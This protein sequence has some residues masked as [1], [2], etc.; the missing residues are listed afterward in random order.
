MVPIQRPPS[1]SRRS[2]FALNGFLAWNRVRLGLAAGE[3]P[4]SA[5]HG[6]EQFSLVTPIEIL[7]LRCGHRIMRWKTGP[8][9]PKPRLRSG[10]KS[11]GAVLI[12]RRN[13]SAQSAVLALALYIAAL[14]CAQPAKRTPQGAG[15]YRALMVLKQRCHELVIKL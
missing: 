6:D 5:T 10:P 7:E 14:Y 9:T 1:W 3:L 4:N 15:P 13:H 11:P 2:R 8:P 12:Q